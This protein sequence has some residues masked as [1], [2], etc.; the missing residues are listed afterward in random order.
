MSV[1]CRTVQASV[2]PAPLP[3]L[4]KAAVLCANLLGSGLGF[5]YMGNIQPQMAQLENT[6]AAAMALYS[7][8][9]AVVHC[10]AA[11]CHFYVPHYAALQEVLTVWHD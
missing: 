2:C 10:V 5:T 7:S 1:F 6:A 3:D 4:S 9:Y 8:A 11:A